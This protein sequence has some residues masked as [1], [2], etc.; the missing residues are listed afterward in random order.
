[1]DPEGIHERRRHGVHLLGQTQG[2]IL[3]SCLPGRGIWTLR[4]DDDHNADGRSIRATVEVTD[5]QADNEVAETAPG[6]TMHHSGRICYVY[7]REKRTR[8]GLGTVG[9]VGS[10]GLVGW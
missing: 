8:G 9:V 2:T 4:V 3:P 5:A 6:G 1:M 7:P 10:M